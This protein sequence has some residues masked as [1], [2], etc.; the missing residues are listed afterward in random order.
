MSCLKPGYN[1]SITRAWSRTQHPCT[2]VSPG[3]QPSLIYIPALKISVPYSSAP[4]ILAM[5][6]KG[7]VLQYKKNSSNLTKNQRF[8]QIARGKW[9]NR[10]TTWATQTDKYTQPNIKLFKRVNVPNNVYLDGTI[11][12]KPITCDPRTPTNEIIV[13]DG[14]TLVCTVQYNPCTG[15]TITQP[16][17]Q[18]CFPTS[19]SN[20]PGPIMDLCYNDSIPTYFPRKQYIM[21]SSGDK[22]PQGYKGLISG[23]DIPSI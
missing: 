17:K 6:N 10:T 13:E 2:F 5:L 22:W 9:T 20:V 18:W 14:G 7:N 15:Q 1:P 8:A 16:P 12:N 19:S 11:T 4:N 23:N 3:E 21:N